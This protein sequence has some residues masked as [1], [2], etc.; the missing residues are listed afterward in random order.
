MK[1]FI[2]SILILI[3]AQSLGQSKS[4]GVVISKQIPVAYAK[5]KVKELN[6]N[7]LTDIKGEF[8]LNDIPNGTYSISIHSIGFQDL[9]TIIEFPFTGLKLDYQEFKK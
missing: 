6:K 7:S 3:S 4:S 9:D 2:V 8:T 5:V 1:F